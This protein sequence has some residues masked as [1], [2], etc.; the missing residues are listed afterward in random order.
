MNGAAGSVVTLPFEYQQLSVLPGYWSHQKS[1]PFGSLPV[2][3][4]MTLSWK[5]LR[6][7]VLPLPTLPDTASGTAI[8][9]EP[10]RQLSQMR[11]PRTSLLLPPP[12]RRPVPT[13]IGTRGI[14]SDPFA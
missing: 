5:R 1:T 11:F 8:S 6:L 3:V 14:T 7:D 4:P 12:I 10:R 2:A 13:G 9:I